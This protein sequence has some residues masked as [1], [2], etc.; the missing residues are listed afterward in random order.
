MLEVIRQTHDEGA[1]IS[2]LGFDDANGVFPSSFFEED[3]TTAF[4]KAD[5]VV[6][7]MSGIDDDGRVDTKFSSASL[8]VRNEALGCLRPGTLVFTGIARPRFEATCQRLE[9]HLIKLMDLDEVAILNSIPTAEG[10]IAMAMDMMD[11]TIHGSKTVIVGFGRCGETLA[12]DLHALSARVRVI[13]RRPSD[14]AR[15]TEMGLVAIPFE[16]LQEAVND[17]DLVINTVPK[18]VLTSDVMDQMSENTVI[19]DIASKPGGT[20]FDYAAKRGLKAKLAPSLPGL[21]APKTAGRILARTISRI[22]EEANS[23]SS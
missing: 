17:A 23:E 5:A 20:D 1:V 4:R 15:I 18:K 22:L 12:R 14:L 16:Q 2:L 10:A 9:L 6:F 19:V 21:V 7:P 3:V 8:V 13:A 11:I